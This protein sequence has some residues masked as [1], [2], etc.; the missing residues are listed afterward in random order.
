MPA[1]DRRPG[2][3]CRRSLAV[4]R[5]RRRV[6]DDDVT[7]AGVGVEAVDEDALADGQRRLHR[8]GRD[9]VWLDDDAWI[10]SAR[11]TAIATSRELEHGADRPRARLLAASSAMSRSRLHV[12]RRVP[13][14]RRLA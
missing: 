10:R 1:G 11:P 8:G 4:G 2:R 9:L 7:E 3:R 13:A 14:T 12:I 5:A 6:K